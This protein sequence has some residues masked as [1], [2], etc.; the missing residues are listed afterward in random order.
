MRT[1]ETLI[2]DSYNNSI[3]KYNSLHKMIDKKIVTPD[4]LVEMEAT[5]TYIQNELI[6][7]G[8]EFD[9]SYRIFIFLIYAD[10]I[11]SENIILKTEEMKK[12]F[13]KFKKDSEEYLYLFYF[14][15]FYF[16]EIF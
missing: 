14:F 11:F 12:R 10:N 15:L 16:Y 7:L 1:L 6:I 9:D 5:K 3:E 2:I 8:K 4:E 13:D